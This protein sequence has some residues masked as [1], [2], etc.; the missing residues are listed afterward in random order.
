MIS[1]VDFRFPPTSVILQTLAIYSLSCSETVKSVMDT[2]NRDYLPSMLKRYKTTHF[3]ETFQKDFE[4]RCFLFSVCLPL[5]SFTTAW[6]VV[7]KY[8]QMTQQ[9][10]CHQSNHKVVC[11]AASF[12]CLQMFSLYQLPATSSNQQVDMHVSLVTFLFKSISSFHEHLS[13]SILT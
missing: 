8:L 1:L 2:G 12:G 10:T 11:H 3:R 4:G 13:K 9:T 7:Y 6:R 5:F